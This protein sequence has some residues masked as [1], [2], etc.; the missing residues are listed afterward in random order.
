MLEWGLILKP[1]VSTT[2]LKEISLPLITDAFKETVLEE[3]LILQFVVSW[4]LEDAP[5][6]PYHGLFQRNLCLSRFNI[7][8][9]C[10]MAA[11]GH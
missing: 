10:E 9:S 5:S 8:V 7:T 4:Q 3:G 11:Q 2:A 1:V 6:T